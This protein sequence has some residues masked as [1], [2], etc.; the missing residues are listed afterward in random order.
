MPTKT[1]MGLRAAGP[2]GSAAIA[3]LFRRF[4]L[5]LIPVFLAGGCATPPP[6][7]ESD[8]ALL[9]GDAQKASVVI[10]R[11]TAEGWVHRPIPARIHVDGDPFLRL[12]GGE[13]VQIHL[14]E[15]RH[16]IRVEYSRDCEL[17]TPDAIQ[18]L[19]LQP[20]QIVY[21]EIVPG[22]GDMSWIF[23]SPFQLVPFPMPG[24]RVELFLQAEEV[25]REHMGKA[26]DDEL[27]KARRIDR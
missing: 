25:A 19:Q 18:T 15:G 6:L 17:V 10:Y 12:L 24:S 21:L 16:E 27:L 1:L 26:L 20:G 7:P 2:P 8:Q 3:C 14:A 23:C 13:Y 22:F 11:S 9:A 5:L 4:L